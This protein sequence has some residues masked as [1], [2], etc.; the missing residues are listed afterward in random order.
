MPNPNPAKQFCAICAIERN[1][2][3]HPTFI[4]DHSFVAKLA[5]TEIALTAEEI[6]WL[7]NYVIELLPNVNRCGR[8][9]RPKEN[10]NVE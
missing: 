4:G 10:R 9:V 3:E 2:H 6:Q 5:S 7:V 8:C 1:I